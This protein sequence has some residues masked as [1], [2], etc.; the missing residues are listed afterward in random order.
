[1]ILVRPSH[2]IIAVTPEAELV[3]EIA[4]R[5]CYKSEGKGNPEGFVRRIVASG[6]E[7]VLEH[8]VVTVRLVTDRGIS[9]QIVRHRLASYSQESTRYCNYKSPRFCNYGK[10]KFGPHVSFV[11][12]TWYPEIPTG[13]FSTAQFV[14][15]N[16]SDS[17]RR[18]LGAMK[19]AE[20]AYFALL[21][22][23]S[24]EQA[25]SVLPNSTKTEI[26]MTANAREWRH[27]FKVRCA[28]DAHIQFRELIC[29]VRDEFA[30][31]WPSVFG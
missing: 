28:P 20:K 26:V 15:G 1:M 31:R 22:H 30:D 2:E 23:E 24:P 29:P 10:G 3:V 27:I 14:S 18:W 17:E 9:H 6:H 13:E 8:M 11:V 16:F 25:R 4:G 5:T 12:P 7:S 19:E 21:E